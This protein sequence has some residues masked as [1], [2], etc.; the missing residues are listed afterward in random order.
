MKWTAKVL[1][2]I[3][4]KILETWDTG[5]IFIS[6]YAKKDILPKYG[7]VNHAVIY[8]SIPDRKID[9]IKARQILENYKIQGKFIL[10]PGRLHPIKGHTLFLEAWADAAKKIPSLELPHVIMAGGGQELENILK[11]TAK[12][13]LDGFIHVTGTIANETML[14]LMKLSDLVVIPSLDETLGNVAIEALKCQCRIISS[15]AGGLPEIIQH[16]ITG[17]LFQSQ[18]QSAL[19][20]LLRK[21]LTDDLPVLQTTELINAYNSKFRLETQLNRLVDL[22]HMKKLN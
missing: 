21:Y 4:R 22:I 9:L 12:H 19:T 5:H 13:R 7:S 18:N 6:E 1:D 3:Q 2:L 16:E 14:G 11:I 15:D 8:N 20:G 10:I 17:Y